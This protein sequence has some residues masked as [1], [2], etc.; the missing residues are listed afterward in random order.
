[1]ASSPRRVLRWGAAGRPAPVQP[2]VETDDLPDRPLRRVGA[3]PFGKPHPQAVT[4]VLLEPAIVT[5]LLLVSNHRKDS[6]G[7]GNSTLQQERGGL[8]R[9]VTGRPMQLVSARPGSQ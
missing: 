8:I 3:G 5:S 6:I 9:D 7:F 4:E 2:W 1:M